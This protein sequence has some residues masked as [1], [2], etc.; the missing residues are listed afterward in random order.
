[1]EGVEEYVIQ[2]TA[3]YYMEYLGESNVFLGLTL[4]AF[5]AGIFFF[6]PLIGVY[7]LKFRR[8]KAIV[9][10]CAM[11][12]VIG[13]A[14]YA[15]PFSG[16]FPLFGR[17]L[18][19]IG[20]GVLGVLYGVLTKCTP[21]DDRVEAFLHFEGLSFHVGA[22]FGLAIDGVLTFNIDLYG[23][24]I[25][26]G[27]SPG[28]ILAI[29][30]FLLFILALFFPSDFGKKSDAEKIDLNI[31]SEKCIDDQ[32]L[33]GEADNGS[34][35]SFSAVCCIYY[36]IFLQMTVFSMIS[37]Y[38]PMLAVYRLGLRVIHVKLIYINSLLAVFIQYNICI[39]LKISEKS[40]FLV[41]VVSSLVS[42]SITLF[43]AL[44]WNGALSVNAAYLLPVSLVI[45]SGGLVNFCLAGSLLSKVTAVKNASV[46]QSLALSTLNI[47][48]IV[49]RVIAGATFSKM[50]M[51][52]ACLGLTIAW[53]FGVIWLALEYKH[54]PPKP[55]TNE[56]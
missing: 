15:I 6:A 13:N 4:A 24:K 28:L 27:N 44:T 41:A 23:W 22:V 35:Y 56:Q 18:S 40:Y 31:E 5:P 11:A 17:F 50:R 12:K 14:L 26:A 48:A 36:L 47:S 29:G 51:I 55:Q 52:Y 7:E 19:G 8:R 37:F 9:V 25:N 54:L 20:N 33:E 3:W 43:F 42:I 45:V 10:I 53:T 30:W 2:S 21:R 32:C 46:Y 49:A 34:D 16:Y 1:M 39:S 38:T